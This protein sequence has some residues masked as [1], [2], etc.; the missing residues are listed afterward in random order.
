MADSVSPGRRIDRPALER[1]IQRAAELQAGER[2]IGEG[3]TEAEVLALGDE[4]GISGV[5]MQRALL[6]EQTRAV[7]T[8]DR[9]PLAWLAGPRV[10]AAERTVGNDAPDTDDALHHW[11]RDGELLV[12]KRRYP[13]RTAWEARRGTVATIKR[14][15]GAG[16]RSYHLAR[17][18]EVVTQVTPVENGRSHVRLL[19]DLANTRRDHLGGALG[20]TITGGGLTAVA[21]TLGVVAP[22]AVL[23]VPLGLALGFSV[24]R[25]RR[26]ELERVQVALEQ[27][28]DKLEHGEIMPPDPVEDV[29]QHP[30]ARI[31]DEIRRQFR[32]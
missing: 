11:M 3:L 10:V 32:T 19:A 31:A 24:A 6:E 4:V 14:S 8:A 7:T 20:L 17:A 25:G 21:L 22:V 2:E 26:S 13:D 30:L 5:H 16:G 23:P 1:I 29:P 27:I 12:I 28:L 15:L 9:G 18:R